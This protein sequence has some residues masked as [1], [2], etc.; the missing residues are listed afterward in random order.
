MGVALRDLV[1]PN[2]EGT[3]EHGAVALWDLVELLHQVGQLSG[4]PRL[5]RCQARPRCRVAVARMA[6]RM[7]LLEALDPGIADA[8]E[9]GRIL[10]AGDARQIAGKRRRQEV[11]LQ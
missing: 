9:A 2:D 10:Q 1:P 3:V 4:V 5:P 6:E 11:D 8:I 7:A